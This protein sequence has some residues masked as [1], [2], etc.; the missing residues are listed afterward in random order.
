MFLAL[1]GLR[2]SEAL[3]LKWSMVSWKE[4]IIHVKRAKQVDRKWASRNDW[5]AIEEEMQNLLTNM[6]QRRGQSEF[7]FPSESDPRIPIPYQTVY[8]GLKQTCRLLK[9][10]HVTLHGL[11]SYFVTGCREFGL[12]DAEIAELIGDKSG[13][14][15]IAE[16]YGDVRPEHLRNRIK[17]VRLLLQTR[18]N[19]DEPVA[20]NV[21]SLR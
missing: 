20:A 16:T 12:L 8:G 10:H 11:R 3:A 21:A 1:S 13:P 19:S 4:Q 15:I 5:V 6:Q 14:R 18:G 17:Q 9:M 7:L 2:I